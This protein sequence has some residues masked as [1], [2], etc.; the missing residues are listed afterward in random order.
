MCHVMHQLTFHELAAD[1]CHRKDDLPAS[2]IQ[3]RPMVA[4]GGL[5][6]PTR[7]VI[8]DAHPETGKAT[9][10]E[11]F[12]KLIEPNLV[13]VGVKQLLRSVDFLRERENAIFAEGLT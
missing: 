8:D 6:H 3:M 7:N 12:I 10:E 13:P 4:A 1:L 9:V 2:H 5:F 11:L